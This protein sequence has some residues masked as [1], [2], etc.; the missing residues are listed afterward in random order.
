M[1]R[2]KKTAHSHHTKEK[3]DKDDK[4]NRKYAK[5]YMKETRKSEKKEKKAHRFR[6]GTKAVMEIRRL[7]GDVGKNTRDATKL[8]TQKAP[9]ERLMRQ[10][11]DQYAWT[12]GM[13]VN[14]EAVEAFQHATEYLCVDLFEKTN[15]ITANSNRKTI[16]MKDFAIAVKSVLGKSYALEVPK[17]HELRRS[18]GK[19]PYKPVKPAKV[20]VIKPKSASSESSSSSDEDEAAP[21]E[22]CV[23]EES[24]K[25][26]EEIAPV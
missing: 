3:R 19:K 23:A 14:P 21:M 24:A 10:L 22:E 11:V 5:K 25:E 7:T 12:D 15:E 9:M 8:L 1:A 18:T 16:A 17:H 6:P 13:R 2:T 26:A 20:T 4:K